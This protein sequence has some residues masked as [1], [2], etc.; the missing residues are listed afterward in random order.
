MNMKKVALL[1]L[2]V[3]LPSYA[4]EKKGPI[5]EKALVLSQQLG[6]LPGWLTPRTP[7]P[8]M[9]A[10]G[11]MMPLGSKSRLVNILRVRVG[12]LEMTWR[13]EGKF[14]VLCRPNEA[15]QFYRDGEVMVVTD[16]AKIKHNFWVVVRRKLPQ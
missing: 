10:H 14:A 7:S 9:L 6:G 5:M 16:S 4:Q 2:L 8:E 3:A 13:E 15:I 12:N 11:N 1:I